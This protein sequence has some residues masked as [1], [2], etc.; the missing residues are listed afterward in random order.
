MCTVPVIN[1]WCVG[2]IF[3]KCV[4][5][6]LVWYKYMVYVVCVMFVCHVWYMCGVRVVCM[7]MIYV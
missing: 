7:F 4:V 1:V 5:G 3:S 6:L 2:S